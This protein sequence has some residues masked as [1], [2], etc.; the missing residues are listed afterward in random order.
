[1]RTITSVKREMTPANY[2]GAVLLILIGLTI[3]LVA[4]FKVFWQLRW[5]FWVFLY[6]QREFGLRVEESRFMQLF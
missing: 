5:E 6:L 4:F 3:S 2:T 1:M